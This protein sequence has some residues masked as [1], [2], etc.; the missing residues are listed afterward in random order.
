MTYGLNIILWLV[1]SQSAGVEFVDMKVHGLPPLGSMAY[2][3]V[4]PGASALSTIAGWQA[5][6]ALKRVPSCEERFTI[7][8]PLM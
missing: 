7:F 2:G 8:P 6:A 5:A 3:M 1:C 4:I